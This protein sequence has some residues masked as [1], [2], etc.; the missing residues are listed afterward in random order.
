ML[1][2]IQRV[3]IVLKEIYLIESTLANGRDGTLIQADRASKDKIF[4]LIHEPYSVIQGIAQVSCSVWRTLVDVLLG[5]KLQRIQNGSEPDEFKIV[6]SYD[7][8]TVDAN[9]DIVKRIMEDGKTKGQDVELTLFVNSVKPQH[10]THTKQD[11]SYFIE[12]QGRKYMDYSLEC[13]S[14]GEFMLQNKKPGRNASIARSHLLNYAHPVDAGVIK[15]LDNPLINKTF[16]ALVDLSVDAEYGLIL[17][18]GIRVDQRYPEIAS[19]LNHCAKTLKMGI[20]YTVVS[21]SVSGMNAMTAGTDEFSF[22][23][24]GS[25]LQA[26]MNEEEMKFVLGHECGHIALGHVVYHTVVSTLRNISELIPVIGPTVYEVTSYPLKA[27]SRRSEISADRAGLLCCGD[28]GVACR[29]LLK[30]EAG[31]M[32]TSGF[33]VADYIQSCNTSLNKFALGKYQELFMEHPILAKRMEALLLFVNSNKYYQITGKEPPC[34]T[35]LLNDTELNLRT[36][37]ILKVI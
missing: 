27:W 3:V 8:E 26:V 31:F 34:G 10:N 16:S 32:N 4:A 37:E 19:V 25:L 24:V 14:F 29:T 21:S 36:E 17:S 6:V 5:L 15:I 1:S 33:D 11:A 22:I 23:A 12:R 2:S 13:P 30:L 28:I 7:P 35:V 18:T 20:P 9:Y